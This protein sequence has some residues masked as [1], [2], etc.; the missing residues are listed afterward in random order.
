[1]A[2]PVRV[3]NLGRILHRFRYIGHNL[4]SKRLMDE[5]GLYVISQIQIRTAEGTDAAGVS[6]AP[7]TDRYRL[8]RQK[9]GHST[10]K[11]NLFFTG[12]MMGSM[13]HSATDDTARVFFMNTTDPSGVSNPLKAYALN[14]DRVFFAMSDEDQRGIERIIQEYI[15]AVMEGH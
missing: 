14:K 6:F 13:T 9:K 12:S 3:V 8:F 7:Y 11:V 5:V 2:E 1:M 4:F 15:E 10:N